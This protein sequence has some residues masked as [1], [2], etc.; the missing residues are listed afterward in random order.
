MVVG[1]TRDRESRAASIFACPRNHGGTG[2]DEEL[3]TPIPIAPTDKVTVRCTYDDALESAE[4]RGA[5]SL[6][7]STN[8]REVRS[9]REASS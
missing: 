4:A 7:S 1:P 9:A 5:T 6:P 3:A 2:G 8:V